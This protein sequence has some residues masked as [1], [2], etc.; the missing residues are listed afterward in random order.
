MRA[1]RAPLGAVRCPPPLC[2]HART[3]VGVAASKAALRLRSAPACLQIWQTEP[4]TKPK[5]YTWY[6]VSEKLAAARSSAGGMALLL[7][8]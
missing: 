2:L 5:T 6:Y 4:K 7:R 1:L 8:L 3:R